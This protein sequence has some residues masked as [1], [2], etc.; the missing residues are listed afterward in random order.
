MANNMAGDK[1]TEE[2]IAQ[3]SL[4]LWSV[5]ESLDHPF[6][7]ID[8]EDY[9]IILAN[10]AARSSVSPKVK[11]CYALSHHRNTPCDGSDHICP[12]A[13]VKRTGNPLKGCKRRYQCA[14]SYFCKIGVQP[15]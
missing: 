9:S 13:E 10:S 14:G 11:T 3:D 15:P 2:Q 4:F 1:Q 5:F 7:V 12:L 8:A 6:L